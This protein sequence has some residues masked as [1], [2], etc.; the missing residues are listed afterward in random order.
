MF[1]SEPMQFR[2]CVVKIKQTIDNNFR[3]S[4]Y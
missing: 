3:T 2:F 1:P 4:C